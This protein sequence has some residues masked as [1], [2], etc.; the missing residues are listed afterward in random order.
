[1]GIIR[2]PGGGL[3]TTIAGQA[4]RNLPGGCRWRTVQASVASLMIAARQQ[5]RAIGRPRCASRVP[6]GTPS[7]RLRIRCHLVSL[8]CRRWTRH[9]ADT[10]P[11]LSRMTITGG[12]DR[13]DTL[14]QGLQKRVIGGGRGCIRGRRSGR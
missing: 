1:M 6:P 8:R 3:G 7:T 2:G 5:R 9:V 14:Q 12:L 10:V 11:E 4:G 13:R